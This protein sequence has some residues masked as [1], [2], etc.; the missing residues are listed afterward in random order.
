MPILIV[1]AAALTFGLVYT[2]DSLVHANGVVSKAPPRSR[3]HPN[4]GVQVAGYSPTQG[5]ADPESL[6]PSYAERIRRLIRNPYA[7]LPSWHS[8]AGGGTSSTSYPSPTKTIR[9]GFAWS[10]DRK[11]VAVDR[12]FVAGENGVVRVAVLGDGTLPIRFQNPNIVRA[13]FTCSMG[14]DHGRTA[15]VIT[16]RGHMHPAKHYR[17]DKKYPF[18]TNGDNFKSVLIYCDLPSVNPSLSNHPPLTLASKKTGFSITIDSPFVRATGGAGFAGAAV[19]PGTLGTHPF[20]PALTAPRPRAGDY[21][22]VHCVCPMYGVRGTRWLIEYLEYHRAA[23]ITH[24]HLYSFDPLTNPALA[25]VLKR[26][27]NLGFV[28]PHDWTEHSSRGFTRRSTYE[29]AKWSAQ[30]DCLLRSRGAADFVVVTDIDEVLLGRTPPGA[31]AAAEPGGLASA[32]LECHR[33]H[34]RSAKTKLG[35]SFNS[36]TVTSVFTQLTPAERLAER[37]RKG[38]LLERYSWE[39]ARPLCPYNCHCQDAKKECRKFHYGRQKYMV[40]VG[41]VS[42]P[43]TLLWTHAI[44]RDYGRGTTRRMADLGMEIL[45]DDLLHVR[46]YQGHWY[47]NDGKINQVEEKASPLPNRLLAPVRDALSG[48]EAL[49]RLYEGSAT[50][51]LDWITPV[52][53][54]KKYHHNP[55]ELFGDGAVAEGG[56]RAS[57]A[58]DT[59]SGGGTGAAAWGAGSPLAEFPRYVCS[60][61]E[62]AA[63][64]ARVKKRFQEWWS[65][66]AC[67]DAAWMD[68]FPALMRSG[69]TTLN[70]DAPLIVLDVGCNKG[71]T[72]ADFM[73]L[74]SPVDGFNP[75][76]LVRAIR[77]VAREAG[78]KFKRDCGVCGDCLRP[79]NKQRSKRERVQVHC[80]EPSPATYQMLTKVRDK[81]AFNQPKP[82][83][84]EWKLHNVGLH[85][86]EGVLAWHPA[87]RD[88]VGDELC[89]IVSEDAPDAIKVGVTTIDAFAERELPKESLIHMLKV[90]A[91]GLDPAVLRGAIETLRKRRAVM[92]M[93]EFNPGLRDKKPPYGMWGTAPGLTKLLDVTKWLDTLSY[94]C[95]LDSRVNSGPTKGAPALYRITGKCLRSDPRIV[96]WS[97]VI[98]ASRAFATVSRELMRLAPM[99]GSASS[100]A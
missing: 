75:D 19:V 84:A 72:S 16:M 83:G 62:A 89:S 24:V 47:I 93:F 99:V 86:K 95:Y 37:R 50:G 34:L 58:G 38:L 22:I 17:R 48:S 71:Y 52:D 78:T 64:E 12:Y 79:K 15:T 21:K 3:Q 10:R 57:K 2:L 9:H 69:E 80:F 5:A 23:G 6:H 73:D 14:Q 49:R 87:C 20:T 27:Q 100:A 4:P 13:K 92:V 41:D 77:A 97:N 91:E 94:D 26:Y 35:C 98:C 44:W 43:P 54:P 90:D 51:G 18:S 25:S 40:Y 60:P 63:Q 66:S 33:A 45:D 28:T 46:H 31:D 7:A 11:F 88:R 61:S 42:V 96:G 8:A 82:G 65:H 53:R 68:S 67:P 85:E 56:G 30:T 76:S 29:H 1:I 39:E 32:A 36:H 70:R 55:A 74:V 59:S 81:L